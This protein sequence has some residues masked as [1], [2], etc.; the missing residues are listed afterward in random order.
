MHSP[1][2][3]GLSFARKTGGGNSGAIETRELKTDDCGS[4]SMILENSSA[5]S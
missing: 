5:K 1:C 2:A 4:E 3:A